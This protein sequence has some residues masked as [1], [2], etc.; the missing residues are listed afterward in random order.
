MNIIPRVA[1]IGAGAQVFK[2][3]AQ[4]DSLQM[5][6]IVQGAGVTVTQNADDI[7]VAATGGTP[8]NRDNQWLPAMMWTANEGNPPMTTVSGTLWKETIFNFVDSVAKSVS[9]GWP[10]PKYWKLGSSVLAR[11]YWKSPSGSHGVD[12]EW[13]LGAA[14]RKDGEAIAVALTDT[15]NFDPDAADDSVYITPEVALVIPSTG[16]LAAEDYIELRVKRNNGSASGTASFLGLK[17]EYE[18]E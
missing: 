15:N 2:Q 12:V 3:Q 13:I 9:L 10:L 14:A 6:T 7:T 16:A 8:V 18:L 11:L 17:L 5:R 4:D 1:N